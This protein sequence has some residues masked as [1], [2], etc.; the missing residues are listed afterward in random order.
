MKAP[1]ITQRYIHQ[2]INA[3]QH[4]VDNHNVPTTTNKYYYCNMW[5]YIHLM[6][7]TLRGQR[8]E[9]TTN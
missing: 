9:R 3:K 5:A 4:T 7:S 1:T 8:N 2:S 6:R